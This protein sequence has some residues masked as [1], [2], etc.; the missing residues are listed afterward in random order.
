MMPSSIRKVVEGI[1]E[2]IRKFNAWDV[3]H[4]RRSGNNAS[5]SLARQAKFLNVCNI[6]VKDTP[7]N[8]ADQVQIDVSQCNL[9][10]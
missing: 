7:P 6:W 10:F 9:F 2:N 3:N 1:L 8:I 4:T 5:H